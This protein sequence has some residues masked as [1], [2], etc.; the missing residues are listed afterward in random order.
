MRSVASKLSQAELILLFL[1]AKQDGIPFLLA[2]QTY[3]VID[4]RT[5]FRSDYL[6]SQFKRRG[7]KIRTV[8]EFGEGKL[9][10][11]MVA[12]K[13]GDNGPVSMSLTKE[14]VKAYKLHLDPK[15]NAKQTWVSHP[16]TMM[17]WHVFGVLMTI[18]GFD[19]TSQCDN[20]NPENLRSNVVDSPI[21]DDETSDLLGMDENDEDP[22][23]PLEEVINQ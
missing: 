20:F 10:R 18:L 23:V 16:Q 14:E 1:R 17:F 15:G 6:L 11:I 4:G 7:G 22:F 5:S 8:A 2:P 12:A 3:H 21:V 13:I 9:N 19:P